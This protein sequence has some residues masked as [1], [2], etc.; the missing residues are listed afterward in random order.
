[1]KNAIR[2][3]QNEQRDNRAKRRATQRHINLIKEYLRLLQKNRMLQRV[4]ELRAQRAQ[5]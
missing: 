2:I 3:L 5:A 4:E 1:M